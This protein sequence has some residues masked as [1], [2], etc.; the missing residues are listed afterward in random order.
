MRSRAPSL[1]STGCGRARLPAPRCISAFATLGV[2]AALGCHDETVS[3]TGPEAAPPL[4]TTASPGLLFR[5]LSV[6]PLHACGVTPDDRAYCWGENHNG[7]LG[8]GT[9]NNSLTPVAVAGGLRFKQVSAGFAFSC[10]VTLDS[11]AY[12]WGFGFDGELG[13]GTG[14][15][16]NVQ[17]LTPV[18][19]AGGRHFRQVRAGYSHACALTPFD[20][21]F[22]WGNNVLGQLGDGTRTRRLTPVRVLGGL[23]FDQ[24]TAG[25][26]VGASHVCGVSLDE[27]AYCWGANYAGQLGDGTMAVSARPVR[28]AGGLRLRQLAAGVSHTCGLT[29]ENR[30]YCWGITLGDGSDSLSRTPVAVAGGF[31]FDHISAGTDYNCAV[32]PGD[33]AYC[34]G[35]NFFGQ[36]GD[37]TT[38]RRLTPIPVVVVG[39]LRFSGVWAGD[40]TTCAVTSDDQA[41]CWNR[42]GLKRIGSTE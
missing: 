24:L 8:D 19:V 35:D 20:V 11:R 7:A 15:P 14:Y 28:V 23:R 16:G 21:A 9:T 17:R 12:C 6:G 34:W 2:L 18:A 13:D 30:A 37:G 22:C 31:R 42:Y 38:T 36:L 1:P 41:Y 26:G 27:R 33:R 5:Q 29:P 40:G 32:T 10:G 4:S 39:A 3:P 25:A